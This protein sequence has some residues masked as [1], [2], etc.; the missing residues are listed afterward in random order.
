M[1]ETA[2]QAHGAHHQA[3]GQRVAEDGEDEDAKGPMG[4]DDAGKKPLQDADRHDYQGK[5]SEK[6]DCL[7]VLMKIEQPQQKEPDGDV[8]YHLNAVSETNHPVGERQAD[9]VE[10]EVEDGKNGV[11][12]DPEEIPLAA[13]A[14]PRDQAQHGDEREEG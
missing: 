12:G 4:V 6:T 8:L 13:I 9:F 7:A 11:D 10:E 2:M 5:N 3:E 14:K 1:F